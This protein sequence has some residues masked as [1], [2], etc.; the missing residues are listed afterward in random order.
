MG[1]VGT[2]L[3]S[4]V[5]TCFPNSPTFCKCSSSYTALRPACSLQVK[6]ACAAWMCSEPLN[7]C[8]KDVPGAPW[9]GHP[10]STGVHAGG[11]APRWAGQCFPSA[12]SF[13]AIAQG[14]GARSH[15]WLQCLSGRAACC[16]QWEIRH[17]TMC[18][19]TEFRDLEKHTNE[20][21]QCV[22]VQVV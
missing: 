21:S 8:G 19:D 17:D 15:R 12:P 7:Q 2:L 13:L 3:I 1:T 9:R 16:T 10:C 4:S 14:T 18:R 11:H 6:R 5:L 20:G 22:K